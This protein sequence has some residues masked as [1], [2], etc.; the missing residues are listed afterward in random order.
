MSSTWKQEQISTPSS[1]MC[2]Q[3][4]LAIA[5]FFSSS[6][7]QPPRLVLRYALQGSCQCLV[8]PPLGAQEGRWWSVGRLLLSPDHPWVSDHAQITQDSPGIQGPAKLWQMPTHRACYKWMTE[9]S[10]KPSAYINQTPSPSL[11]TDARNCFK[12]RQRLSSHN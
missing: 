7:L 2:T 4:P 9:G 5:P 11:L 3:T 10:E 1:L 12:E 6:N 8:A